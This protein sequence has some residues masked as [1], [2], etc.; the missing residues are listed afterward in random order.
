MAIVGSGAGAGITADI[1][2]AA[3]V[4]IVLIEEGPLKSSA[5]LRQLE[6]QA[7]PALYEQ[8]ASRE[9][10]DKAIGILLGRCVGA[11]PR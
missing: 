7:Y 8:S 4:D 9:T 10:A 6:A 1:L 11:P 2:T 3:G 5:D